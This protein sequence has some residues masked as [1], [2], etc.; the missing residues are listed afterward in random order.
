MLLLSAVAVVGVGVI[1]FVG[2]AA[3]HMARMLVGRE[4][5]W[6]LPVA[7]LLGAVLVSVSDA[8]GRTVIAPDQLPAGLVVAVL[9][10]PYLLWLLKRSTRS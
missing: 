1:S 4:Q 7:A 3:P 9:G 2:L 10:P 5:R 6:F 8:F